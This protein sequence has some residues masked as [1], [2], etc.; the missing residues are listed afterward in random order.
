MPF[1]TYRTGRVNAGMAN[2]TGQAGF[3]L[4][5][6]MTVVAVI[7]VFAAMAIPQ[8]QDYATRVRWQDN[9]LGVLPIKT[10]VAQCAQHS[11]GGFGAAPCDS[12]ANLIS[13]SYLPP[14]STGIGKFANAVAWNGAAIQ[15]DG[16]TAARNCVVSFTPVMAGGGTHLSWSIASA[17][18]GCS[19]ARIGV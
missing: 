16:N 14:G 1:P 15:I 8:Y 11:S 17:T 13:A 7:G 2:R 6:L 12:L 19:R 3:T 10:A 4:V 18:P 9:Y 5:E